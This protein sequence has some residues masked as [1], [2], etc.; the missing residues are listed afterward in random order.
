MGGFGNGSLIQNGVW[1]NGDGYYLSSGSTFFAWHEYIPGPEIALSPAFPFNSQDEFEVW[2]EPCDQNGYLNVNGGYAN[3]WFY[4]F[5]SG[6]EAR[7]GPYK[8]PSGYGTQWATLE[9]IVEKPDGWNLDWFSNTHMGTYG[10]RVGGAYADVT[11]D[12]WKFISLYGGTG[13][14]LAIPYPI[15]GDP[16]TNNDYWFVDYWENY[17]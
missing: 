16:P 11:T 1:S 8:A 9:S 14:L 12:D 10:Y 5:V 15:N 7:E 3:Y 13:D 6:N 2:G 17:Q 4:D